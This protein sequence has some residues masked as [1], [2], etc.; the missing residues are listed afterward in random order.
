M[1]DDLFPQLESI[2]SQSAGI[3]D[4]NSWI[5]SLESFPDVPVF[6]ENIIRGVEQNNSFGTISSSLKVNSMLNGYHAA[7]RTAFDTV[8]ELN[9][10]ESRLNSLFSD[11]V[12][13]AEINSIAINPDLKSR[14]LQMRVI[15]QSLFDEKEQKAW[16]VKPFNPIGRGFATTSYMLYE[17]EEELDLIARLNPGANANH[18][19][20]LIESLS[21]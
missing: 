5:S 14:L 4:T 10:T 9:L 19:E 17:S 16:K 15:A 18:P 1:P 20:G 11:V 6:A 21:R 13:N 7:I 2:Y 12:E 3:G 8:P